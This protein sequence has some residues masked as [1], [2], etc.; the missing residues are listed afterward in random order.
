M[1]KTVNIGLIDF[2]GKVVANAIY[3]E[4]EA[5]KYKEGEILAKKDDKYGVI[6]NKGKVLIPFEY[7]EI[8]ADTYYDG[9][10]EKTGYIVKKETQDGYKYGYIDYKWKK[11]L[12]SEYTEV[13]RL[14]EV[15]GKDIYLVVAKNGQYGLMKNKS[16]VIDFAYQSIT[17]N[18]TANLLV[19][20]R[21]E[22]YGA[23][24]L[25]GKNIIPIEYR[26][27]KFNGTYVCAKAYDDDIYF[28]QKG[29]KVEN[30]FIGM[31]EIENLGLCIST[32]SDNL[33]G[34]VDK[35]GK[36]IIEN[37]YL[38]MD[39]LFDKYFVANKQ[40]NGVIDKDN[41]VIV[42]FK[43]DV[44]SKVGDKELLKA[45]SMGKDGDEV[46]IFSKDFN[47]IVKLKSMSIAIYDNYIEAYNSKEKVFIDNNGKIIS[48]KELFKDNKLFAFSKDGKWGFENRN[49]ETVIEPIYENVSE[50]NR[51]GFASIKQDGKWGAINENGE[52]ID[53]TKFYFGDG[54]LKPEFLG[55]YYRTHKENNE[56]MYTDEVDEDAYY[57]NE[58]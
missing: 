24:D 51:Y 50:F 27:I 18:R 40:G 3:D 31:K 47:E 1:K 8:V 39:H 43:Y 6:N 58:L 17:Y 32:N 55:K 57:E 22:K 52:A 10:Y 23:F 19:V 13:S 46:T 20:Q 38:Y 49:G 29:E 35:D 25:G 16:K 11:F 36:T 44:L 42:D 26:S 15:D 4:L 5:V 54:N 34:L 14:V 53:G 12:D 45:V 21:G 30:N 37:S 9:T 33:Y 7:K 28:N 41:N 48:S 56:V 2:N